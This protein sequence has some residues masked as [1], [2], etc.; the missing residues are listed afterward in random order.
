M[1]DL[2]VK[3]KMYG[4]LKQFAKGEMAREIGAR[5]GRSVKLP[6]DSEPEAVEAAPEESAELDD[7]K[8]ELDEESLKALLAS[9]E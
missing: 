6:W 8:V 5:H 7:P 1:S 9:L 2:E 3:R 4:D